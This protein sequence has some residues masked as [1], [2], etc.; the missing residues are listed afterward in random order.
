MPSHDLTSKIKEIRSKSGMSQDAFAGILGV[1][2]SKIQNIESGK[3]RV[4]HDFLRGLAVHFTVDINALLTDS[5]APPQTDDVNCT[6]NQFI[7]V[8]RLE[9][10]AS[11]GNG[12]EVSSEA[13]TQAYA[14]NR[15]WLDKRGLKPNT[16]S[17]ISV[18]GDSM[19]PDLND[20]DLVLIDLANTDLADGKIYAV[21]YSGNLFV[22][23]VQYIPG[24]TVRLVSRNAQYAPIEIKTPE[25]D[26]VRV[27]G[28]VVASMHEW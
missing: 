27:V 2:K 3:Q 21:Q 28:R 17:V 13:G 15:K 14:F 18:R 24:D 25:A 26:G 9:V 16:L 22:K 12:S 20:G 10:E 4:D 11:A 6:S 7:K 23:R 19:E 5:P 1:S 8:P